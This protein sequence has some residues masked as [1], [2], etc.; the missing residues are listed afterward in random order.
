MSLK[1]L[2]AAVTKLPAHEL[3]DF[4][5]WFEEYLEDAWDRQI[6]TDVAAGKLDALGDKALADHKAGLSTPL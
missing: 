6:E 1:E 4:T 2:E 3:T 5:R